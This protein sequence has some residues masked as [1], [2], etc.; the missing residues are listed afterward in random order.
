MNFRG[1]K[2]WMVAL[3]VLAAAGSA[4]G[5]MAGGDYLPEDVTITGREMHTFADAGEPVAVVLGDFKLTI[6]RRTLAAR[7]AVLWV[8][9]L[10]AGSRVLRQIS[11]YAEGDVV[12][13]EPNAIPRHAPA[14][15][16]NIR[17][18][19]ALRAEVG[20]HVDEP[21]TELPLY[22]RAK[23]IR[24]GREPLPTTPPPP[25]ELPTRRPAAI[26]P[27]KKEPFVPQLRASERPPD[28]SILESVRLRAGELHAYQYANQAGQTQQVV[29]A[30]GDVYGFIEMR[31][32]AAV[33]FI[34]ASS[35][36]ADQPKADFA[37][38]P[39]G[40]RITEVY[41][42]GDVRVQLGDRS[43]RAGRL[44]YDFV[45]QQAVMLEAV[46]Q[47]YEQRRNIPILFRADRAVQLSRREFQFDHVRISTSEFRT[48]SFDVSAAHAQLKDQTA[49]DESGQPAG[50]RE[51]E[52]DMQQT[53]FNVEGVPVLYWPRASLDASMTEPPLRSL[54][55]G[56][57]GHF[58]QGAST[59]WD[60]FRTL[61]LRQPE[62]VDSSLLAEGYEQ[63]AAFGLD[64][65]YNRSSTSGLV[66][67]MYVWDGLRKDD[68]GFDRDN[69]PAPEERGRLLW[70]QKQ[71]LADDWQ[72]QVE[73]SY[74]SDK[75]Y[76]QEFD[77]QEFWAGKE[78][79]TLVYAE[80]QRDDW[81]VT[82]LVKGQINDF[83]PVSEAYPDLGAYKIGTPALEDQLTLF[84]EAHLGAVKVA[85]G[86]DANLPNSDTTGRLA[87]RGEA[88]AP[89]H[90]GPVNVAPYTFGEPGFWSEGARGEDVTRILGGGGLRADMHL[91]RVYDDVHSRLFDLDRMRHVVTPEATVY[92]AA[93]NVPPSQLLPFSPDLE[94][95]RSFQGA[96]FGVRQRWQTYRG[97]EDAKQVVDFARLDVM[98]DIYNE[99]E[100]QHEPADGRMFL[101]RPEYSI[102]RNAINEDSALNI[103][104]AT[105]ILSRA[106]YDLNEGSLAIGDLG[107]AVMREP[108]LR[109]YVGVRYIQDYNSAVGTF[110]I[111][112]QVNELYSVDL[113]QQSDFAFQGGQNLVT[114]VSI[115]RHFPRWYGALSV[116]VDRATNEVGAFITIWPEGAPEFHLSGTRLGSW[117]TSLL[118]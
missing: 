35:T 43:L 55:I 53:T 83:Q 27:R 8:S 94:T 37:D 23:A 109:Y 110:G 101:R 22:Q 65:D 63:E 90:W 89:M 54:S 92:A 59:R 44:V 66:R 26:A 118:N 36:P 14:I 74:L 117:A 47:F 95:P 1:P 58:G 13:T 100:E 82:A 48:P 99:P 4:L 10:Q 70:R 79:E 29:I 93:D 46:L 12:T 21:L 20:R 50:Q 77:R 45:H 71:Y 5:Q 106:N 7:D 111:N 38:R 30:R 85:N 102:G 67:S 41:L 88:D 112:Y 76:L 9:E 75:N 64:A 19:G 28:L 3:A 33:V 78:Q 34:A 17:Q 72:I 57:N 24:Q 115:V 98:A 56:S 61:G 6:G 107:V 73:V 97:S 80:K 31:A 40:Q 62:G 42:E 39:G 96:E 32:D 69:I 86:G 84:G 52:I 114:E 11:V 25:V 18:E 103:S 49:Y 16:V 91:W 105:S 116:V 81:A 68:F 15:L 60:L 108:R 113:F 104:D 87:L 51:F 2:A